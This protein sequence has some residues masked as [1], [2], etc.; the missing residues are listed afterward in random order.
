MKN[1]FA[2]YVP[3][4][5]IKGD[6]HALTK[7]EFEEILNVIDTAPK[8]TTKG[9]K[10]TKTT[11]YHPWLKDGFKLLL[12]LGGR[13]EEIVMLRWSDI[14]VTEN[15]TKFFILNNLKMDR[16]LKRTAPKKYVPINADLEELLIKLG[17]NDKSKMND[18]VLFPERGNMKVKT[19]MSILTKSFTYYKRATGI[20]KK[21]T[22]KN[23]RKTYIT[24]VENYMGK[25][26]GKL[27]SHATGEVIDKY[28]LDPTILSV[29]ER[30]AL[31][32]KIFGENTTQNPTQQPG[33]E[34]KK[35]SRFNVSP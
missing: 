16:I 21:I 11:M 20:S 30:G 15:G 22:L 9:S 8:T 13:R 4:T 24:W 19:I 5:V 35:D 25:D 3:K 1:P 12:L 2:I 28:Y 26:T 18:Y 34:T 7:D 23:L 33:A 10:R 6:I 32:I 31:D 17:M 14:F 27:T 29:V